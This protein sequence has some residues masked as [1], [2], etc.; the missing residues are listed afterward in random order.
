MKTKYY[1]FIYPP[2]YENQQYILFYRLT[3][4]GELEVCFNDLTWEESRGWVCGKEIDLKDKSRFEPITVERF[5]E[6]LNE[7]KKQNK[8]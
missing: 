1:R 7:Y 8:A 6:L 3:T 5:L 2:G 4:S